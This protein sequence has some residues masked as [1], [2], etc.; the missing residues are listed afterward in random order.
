MDKYYLSLGAQFK[1]EAHILD[2]WLLHYVNCCVEQFFLMN[3]NS[4]DNF[5]ECVF[6]NYLRK[7]GQITL[8][9]LPKKTKQNDNINKFLIPSAKCWT[10][11]LII[12]DL[13]E[14]VYS[15]N[16]TSLKD[17]VLKYDDYSAIFIFWKIFLTSNCINQPTSVLH[18]N[19]YTI[20]YEDYPKFN[21]FGRGK[22][23]IN[24]EKIKKSCKHS[25]FIKDKEKKNKV[26]IRNNNDDFDINH[27]R[28]QSKEFLLNVKNSRGGG[29]NKEKYKKLKE[30]LL[31][32]SEN[33][34]ETLIKTKHLHKSTNLIDLPHK[35]PYNDTFLRDRLSLYKNIEMNLSCINKG[36]YIIGGSIDNEKTV[37]CKYNMDENLFNKYNSMLEFKFSYESKYV[38]QFTFSIDNL[39]STSF[40]II[41]K[42]IDHDDGWGQNLEINLN[43]WIYKK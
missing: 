4:N 35:E 38:D 19:I 32:S 2:E 16:Y 27:Y 41:T 21:D 26:I 23:I 22:G 18:S 15:K 8:I 36:N 12:C 37:I 6:Y 29:T 1:N 42:R 34:D 39:T 33:I 10:K 14:F 28:Y 17:A 43:I 20:E 7:R 11:W 13:D 5:K 31:S 9:N 3:D 24:L 25:G 40:H 30:I